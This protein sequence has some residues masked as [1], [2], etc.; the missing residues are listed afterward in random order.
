M[1]KLEGVCNEWRQDGRYQNGR[2]VSF[3]ADNRAV[4]WRVEGREVELDGLGRCE[5]IV[6][7]RV[8]FVPGSKLN[9]NTGKTYKM[10]LKVERPD[11]EQL[12]YRN[13][14]EVCV[15]YESNFLLR[16][17]GGLLSLVREDRELLQDGVVVECGVEPNPGFLMWRATAIHVLANSEAEYET[18]F[19]EAR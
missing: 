16:K 11:K 5:L 3:D 4:W 19:P 9:K 15:V 8:L 18:L 10:A 7:E 6:N 12:D 1:S 14:L 2:I 13:H 17:R